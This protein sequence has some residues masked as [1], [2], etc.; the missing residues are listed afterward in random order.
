M[1]NENHECLV[2]VTLCR[3]RAK[4]WG[5]ARLRWWG[6][7]VVSWWCGPGSQD[8]VISVSCH[9]VPAADWSPASAA[10]WLV[11]WARLHYSSCDG[12]VTECRA[13]LST[14]WSPAQPAQPSPAQHWTSDSPHTLTSSCRGYTRYLATSQGFTRTWWWIWSILKLVQTQVQLVLLW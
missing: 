4:A 5:N 10:L 7:V 1:R 8:Y 13:D 12:C 9:R 6:L 11:G 3:G 2:L 14:D